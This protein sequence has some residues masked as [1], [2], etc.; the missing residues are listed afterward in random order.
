MQLYKN[1]KLSLNK[2]KNPIWKLNSAQPSFTLCLGSEVCNEDEGPVVV[3]LNS[4]S[5]SFFEEKL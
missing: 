5:E 4:D 1:K 3:Y 2:M